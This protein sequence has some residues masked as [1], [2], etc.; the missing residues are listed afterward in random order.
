MN[1]KCTN[2]LLREV[3]RLLHITEH[4][5]VPIAVCRLSHIN[6]HSGYWNIVWMNVLLLRKI[7]V[8]LPAEFQL[9]QQ[10]VP[11]H[12]ETV[13]IYAQKP[14]CT[15]CFKPAGFVRIITDHSVL[16]YKPK[17]TKYA[18]PQTTHLKEPMVKTKRAHLD[19]WF[20]AKQIHI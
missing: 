2:H 7:F 18:V 1:I 15:Y 6:N 16:F 10:C 8:I 13:H 17:K 3:E 20:L 5:I 12:L 19:I 11:L 4:C 9:E 14:K